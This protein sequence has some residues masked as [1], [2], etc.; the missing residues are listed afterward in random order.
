MNFSKSD[1]ILHHIYFQVTSVKVTLAWS[2]KFK[3]NSLNV[4]TIVFHESFL[5]GVN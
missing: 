5:R 3:V 1:S 4:K 2:I